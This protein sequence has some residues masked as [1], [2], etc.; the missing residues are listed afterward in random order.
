MPLKYFLHWL[1]E[2]GTSPGFLPFTSW[3]SS[4]PHSDVDVGMISFDFLFWQGGGHRWGQGI[5]GIEQ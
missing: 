2:Y 4:F 1:L 3:L 5:L